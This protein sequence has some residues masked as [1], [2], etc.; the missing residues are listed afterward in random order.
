MPNQTAL[1]T[2]RLE[3]TAEVRAKHSVTRY[4]RVG[5]GN[6]VILLDSGDGPDRLWP[7]LDAALSECCRLLVPEPPPSGT[8]VTAW[9]TC[10]LDG[11]GLERA[12]LVAADRFCLPMLELALLDGDRVERLVLVAE[13]EG[14]H[15]G[16]AG[17]LGT[18]ASRK[19]PL[20]FLRR[21]QPSREAVNLVTGFLV[22][23]PP[24]AG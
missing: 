13:G 4:R 22:G 5:S 21:A 12:A 9:L 18:P 15:A 3:T 2:A 24:S 7:Q 14:G 17:R 10:F 1:P 8:D 11:L 23:S 6:P 20:L 19:V 16:L